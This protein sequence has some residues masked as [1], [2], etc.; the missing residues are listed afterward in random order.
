MEQLTGAGSATLELLRPGLTVVRFRA[1]LKLSV[2][3]VAEVMMARRA[4]A[5]GSCSAI[6][7]IPEY[8]DYD[9]DLLAVDH[10]A[11]NGLVHRTD[12]L[13]IVCQ[14]LGLT[15]VLRL[16]FAYHPPPFAFTFCTSLEEAKSWM[17][18]RADVVT[19]V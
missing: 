13:A 12:A 10:F 14:E 19:V 18:Q 7:L 2:A 4:D 5:S 9:V 15:P 11:A 6:V 16:Y 8:T 3:I 17:R 1:K